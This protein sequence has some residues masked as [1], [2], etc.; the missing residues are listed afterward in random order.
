MYES[1]KEKKKYQTDCGSFKPP[2]VFIKEFNVKRKSGRKRRSNLKH[3]KVHMHKA[4]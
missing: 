3:H 4:E 2:V 1:E